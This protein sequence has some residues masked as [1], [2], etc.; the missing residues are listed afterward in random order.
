[1][2]CHH[3]GT[4]PE[5]LLS[6]LHSHLDKSIIRYFYLVMIWYALVITYGAD[7]GGSGK[8]H[9]DSKPDNRIVAI[10]V[11]IDTSSPVGEAALFRRAVASLAKGGLNCAG[12]NKERGNEADHGCGLSCKNKQT[13]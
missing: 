5:I 8:F 3:L 13:K 9:I 2:Q 4:P 10:W 12:Q 11:S 1:M 7:I 6:L